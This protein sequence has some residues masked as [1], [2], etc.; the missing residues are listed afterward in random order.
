MDRKFDEEFVRDGFLPSQSLPLH[1]T[2]GWELVMCK[3]LSGAS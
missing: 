2:G 3:T 1:N